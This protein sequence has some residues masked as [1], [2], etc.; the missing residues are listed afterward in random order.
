M[1]RGRKF[2]FC[3]FAL[4]LFVFSGFFASCEDSA[5]DKKEP[6]ETLETGGT[7]SGGGSPT[8][9]D[10]KTGEAAPPPET[11]EENTVDIEWDEWNETKEKHSFEDGLFW[12][13]DF[14]NSHPGSKYAPEAE[15]LIEKIR[16]DSSYS[17]KYLS[18]PTLELIDEFISKFPGHKDIERAYEQRKNFSGDIHT[19]I[20]KGYIAAVSAGDSIK[21]NLLRIQNKTASKL[22]VTIPFGTYFA[23]NSGNVQNMLARKEKKF[24]VRANQSGV[25]YI[26]TACMNIYKDAPGENDYFTVEM[27]PENSRLIKLLKVLE[28]N[29]VSC[30]IAQAAIWQ[31]ADNPGKEAILGALVYENGAQ[32]ITASDYEEALRLLKESE[33]SVITKLINP[34]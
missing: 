27:L 21:G 2:L 1:M 23:A 8:E 24:S 11:T 6:G 5:K 28:E 14:V 33:S 4:S 17:E 20:K 34:R 12:L 7:V 22:E 31:A 15:A 18:E 16:G 29:E 13:T 3:F 19:M 30:E 26:E 10:G 9:S 25:L 32:A